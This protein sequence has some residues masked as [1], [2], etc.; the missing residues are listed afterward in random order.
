MAEGVHY[1]AR[2]VGTVCSVTYP[3]PKEDLEHYDYFGLFPLDIGH[4]ISLSIFCFML[5]MH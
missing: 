4:L 3:F 2:E 1:Q 5:H